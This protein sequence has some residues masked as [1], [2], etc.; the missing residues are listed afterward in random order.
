MYIYLCARYNYN[1]VSGK[2]LD[3]VRCLECGFESSKVSTFLDLTLPIRSTDR[4]EN[5]NF[6][7]RYFFSNVYFSFSKIK[8]III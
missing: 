8:F 1:F 6:L 4:T 7:V 5:Y 2:M 3:Y